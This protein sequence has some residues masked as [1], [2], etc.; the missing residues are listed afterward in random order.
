MW[1]SDSIINVYPD[2]AVCVDRRRGV[3][4]HICG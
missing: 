1:Q 2:V 4:N 3:W